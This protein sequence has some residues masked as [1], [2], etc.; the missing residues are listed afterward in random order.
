M[1]ASGPTSTFGATPQPR[2]ARRA[3]RAR[4]RVGDRDDAARRCSAACAPSSST[5]PPPAASADDREPVGLRRTTSSA[6]VPTDPV[7]PSMTTSRAG[8]SA[9]VADPRPARTPAR[10][11]RRA[12]AVVR[13]PGARQDGRR[14]D[15]DR[16]D[17]RGPRARDR[18]CATL[19][20][21]AQP[22]ATATRT[23][24]TDDPPPRRRARAGCCCSRR[25]RHGAWAAA[26]C[27]RCAETV[28]RRRAVSIGEVK[29]VYV[30]PGR[31]GAGSRGVLMDALARAGGREPATAACGSRRAP[32]SPRRWRSTSAAAG[33][34]CPTTASTPTTRA[35]VCF[36]L[37]LPVPATGRTPSR[38]SA[39]LRA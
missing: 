7:L 21:R 3:G 19:R 13:R 29:R 26:R 16:G 33:A 34:A 37:D 27:S 17:R 18:C 1:A 15:D 22:S 28:A 24:T 39:A 12:P 6:W 25:R 31:A 20:H 2:R 38:T 9:I 8:T 30:V 4:G 35:A 36:A 5:S 32:R 23:G 14:A 10:R 11:V